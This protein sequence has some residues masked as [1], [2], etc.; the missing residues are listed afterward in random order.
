MKTEAWYRGKVLPEEPSWRYERKFPIEN[1]QRFEIEQM[2]RD[3]PLGFSTLY[4]PRWNNSIYCESPGMDSFL[5]HVAGSSDRVKARI[6]WY[7]EM[8]GPVKAILELKIKK[9]LAGRKEYYPMAP[10]RMTE[11]LHAAQ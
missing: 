1:L 7:G 2:L 11:K 4:P 9:G 5:E 10:F 3:H 8:L 6:R